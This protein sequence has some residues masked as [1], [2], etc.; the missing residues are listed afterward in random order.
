[1]EK[2]RLGRTGHMSTVVIFGGAAFGQISQEDA[3][4]ALD[5]ALAHGVN[6]LDIAPSYGQSEERTG[7]WLERQ[8]RDQFFVGCKTLERSRQGAWAELQRSLD[9]LRVKQL[10]LYQL[11]AI[12]NFDGLNAALAQGGAIETLMEAREKGLTKYLGITGHGLDSP[13]VF[14]NALERFDFDTVMFP[15]HPRLYA[16]PTYRGNAERLLQMCAD[17]EVGVMIIKSITRAAWGTQEKNYNTWYQPYDE[18]QKITQGVRFAL[19]QPGVTGVPSAGDTR[20][21]PMV[22]EAA[23]NF[24]P[25]SRDEQEALIEQSRELDPMFF[26]G[27]KF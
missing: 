25:M 26:Q 1:M 14:A 23:D 19:S 27:Q 3:N 20:L 16:D 21:L 7:P 4:A 18:Q 5:L 8:N 24:K 12:T 11:H 13:E 2:R 6:H 9:K 10:D 22:L 15:I 17:R